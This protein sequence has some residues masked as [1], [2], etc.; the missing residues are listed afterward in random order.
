M[1]II[2]RKTRAITNTKKFVSRF[3]PQ[4]YVP[5]FTTMKDFTISKGSHTK[6]LQLGLHK[7]GIHNSTN[8]TLYTR[9]STKPI[10]VTKHLV[11]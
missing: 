6:G 7:I 3:E 10:E 11:I 8:P 9:G 4:F 1:K 2:E 5:A